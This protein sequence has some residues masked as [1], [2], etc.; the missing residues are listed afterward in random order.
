MWDVWDQ[1]SGRR[2]S[3]V[4]IEAEVWLCSG[5]G[6][7]GSSKSLASSRI[8][9]TKSG[10]FVLAPTRRAGFVITEAAVPAPV[11]IASARAPLRTTLEAAA[12]A[13]RVVGAAPRPKVTVSN[14]AQAF[15]HRATEDSDPAANNSTKSP[16]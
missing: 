9:L 15:C 7:S 11:L 4:T 12:P 2:V 3:G 8:P 1:R 16:R 10:L 14:T 13:L 6:F 5:E